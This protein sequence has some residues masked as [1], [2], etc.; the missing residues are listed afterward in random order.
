MIFFFVHVGI[1][2]LGSFFA[3]NKSIFRFSFH[4]FSCKDLNLPLVVNKNTRL[5][6]ISMEM[7]HMVK[8]RPRK[9]Q[10]GRA[11]LPQG[12]L[13]IIIISCD[14]IFKN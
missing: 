1:S 10:S 2:L 11:N 13:A 8:S 6:T 7:V 12:Y 4:S 9:F 5:M 14:N 3:K